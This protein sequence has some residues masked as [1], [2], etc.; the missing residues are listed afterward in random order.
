MERELGDYLLDRYWK[1]VVFKSNIL[2]FLCNVVY[3][4][5]AGVMGCLRY[6]ETIMK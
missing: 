6:F 1:L 4:A 2:Y 5:K 3:G